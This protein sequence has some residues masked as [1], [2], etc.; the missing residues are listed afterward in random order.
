MLKQ[1]MK[2]K[3]KMQPKQKAAGQWRMQFGRL[4]VTDGKP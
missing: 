3:K 1:N 2:T 4:Q